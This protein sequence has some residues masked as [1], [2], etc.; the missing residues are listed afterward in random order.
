MTRTPAVCNWS[1]ICSR[2]AAL[3]RCGLTTLTP[4]AMV[5]L[6]AADEA[7]A[8]GNQPNARTSAREIIDTRFI[9]S[10]V[11][12]FGPATHV[13]RAFPA[14]FHAYPAQ[15]PVLGPRE[16]RTRGPG[17]NEQGEIESFECI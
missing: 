1:S 16:A 9:Q 11:T 7:S 12:W 3:R 8:I 10:L 4:T 14:G 6:A 17:T 2:S 15:E 5:S 13:L